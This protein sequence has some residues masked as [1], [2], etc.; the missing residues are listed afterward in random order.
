M[1]KKIFLDTNVFLDKLTE[2]EPFN[3]SASAIL[4]L[5]DTKVLEIFMSALSFGTINYVLGKMIGKD[6]TKDKLKDLRKI[7]KIVLFDDKI[8]E[9]SLYS[10]FTDTEDAF[11]YFSALEANAELIITR[12]IK[13]FKKSSIPVKTPEEFLLSLL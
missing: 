10:N 6:L 8:I 12:N 7:C 11:Q 3:K 13:D 2:R 4:S 9:N 5:A 1:K